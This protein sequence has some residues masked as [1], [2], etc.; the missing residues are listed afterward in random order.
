MHGGLLA[1]YVV[2]VGCGLA[3]AFDAWRRSASEWTSADRNRGW[4]ITYALLGAWLAFG[5]V[6]AAAYLIGVVPHFKSADAVN[7]AFRK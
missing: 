2:S 1:Y 3:V 4:W 5:P 7:E 6:L